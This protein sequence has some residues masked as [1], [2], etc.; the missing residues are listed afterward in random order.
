[1]YC[2]SSSTPSSGS[3]ISA[4]QALTTSVRYQQVRDP[5]RQHFGDLLG[6]VVVR[7]IVNGFLVQVRQQLVG[8][9]LHADLGVAH[10]SGGVAVD[11]A[12]VALPVHQHIAQGEGL[13]HADDGVVDRGIAV[14]VIFTD[15]V[16]DDT[17]R[18]L[19]GLVPVVAELVHGEKHAPVHGLE[20]VADVRQGASD[21]DAHGVVHVGLLE[22][23]FDTYRE[24][25]LG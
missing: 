14:R 24:D 17:G 20:A 1:M 4:R 2:I 6:A 11:G 22:L 23:V 9:L 16:A 19:V 15:D 10:G 12:E 21:N 13:G 7:H 25:F 3:S 18:L 8:N 5:G